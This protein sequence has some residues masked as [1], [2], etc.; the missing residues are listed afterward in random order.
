MPE[1]YCLK[2]L[3]YLL[4]YV[5]CCVCVLIKGAI[6]FF[7]FCCV[8]LYTVYFYIYATKALLRIVPVGLLVTKKKVY[9]KNTQENKI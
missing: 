3:R 6:R 9:L 4:Y 8:F 1:I 5:Q 7:F 2:C